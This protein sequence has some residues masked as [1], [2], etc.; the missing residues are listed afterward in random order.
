M[1]HARNQ[2]VVSSL[3]SATSCSAASK[4]TRALCTAAPAV[5]RGLRLPS[6][7]IRQTH[8]RPRGLRRNPPWPLRSC[9]SPHG[10]D[11]NL[12][13]DHRWP[14]C[15]PRLLHHVVR[16]ANGDCPSC[17][18]VHRPPS[19][20]IQ[21]HQ[22]DLRSRG[23]SPIRATRLRVR[24]ALHRLPRHTHHQRTRSPSFGQRHSPT[25][26]IQPCAAPLKFVPCQV[27]P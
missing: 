16:S 4:H 11:H 26:P 27:L 20:R 25:S 6:A 14:F 12:H 24:S 23:P 9:T 5:H 2:H 17:C 19:I 18:N 10:M 7:W 21:L 8:S 15:A 13:R 1:E 22:A 3:E